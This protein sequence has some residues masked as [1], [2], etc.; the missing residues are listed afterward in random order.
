[1]MIISCIWLALLAIPALLAL[2]VWVPVYLPDAAD[3]ARGIHASFILNEGWLQSAPHI[4]LGIATALVAAAWGIVGFRLLPLRALT[5]GFRNVALTVLSVKC[6]AAYLL[7][8]LPSV[9]DPTWA[10]WAASHLA[11]GAVWVL[12]ATFGLNRI[13]R[14]NIEPIREFLGATAYWYEQVVDDPANAAY[15]KMADVQAR[16]EQRPKPGRRL[17]MDLRVDCV[18]LAPAILQDLQSY[19][20]HLDDQLAPAPADV[21]QAEPEEL[22]EGAAISDRQNGAREVWP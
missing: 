11:L 6:G 10:A 17:A 18:A 20:R 22:R 7:M 19:L 4:W 9:P 3:T 16:L 21:T 1:M 5:D 14:P 15:Q 13:L 12:A 8:L 2:S